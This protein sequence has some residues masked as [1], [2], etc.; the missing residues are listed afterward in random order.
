MTKRVSVAAITYLCLKV[1]YEFLMAIEG[2]CLEVLRLPR[3]ENILYDPQNVC[4]SFY[5]NKP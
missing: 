2:H 5:Y 1:C 3:R 4:P